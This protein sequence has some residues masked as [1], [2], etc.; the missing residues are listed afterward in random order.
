LFNTRGGDTRWDIWSYDFERRK[1]T[2][3]VASAFNETG[4]AFSPDGKWIAFT[5]DAS[6]DFQVYIQSSADATVQAQVSTRGGVQPQWRR[7]GKELYYVA[8]DN[9]IMAAAIDA[10]AGTIRAAAPQPLFTANIDQTS[11]LRNQY[12]VSA[13]GQRF[14]LLSLVNRHP[15]PIVV[16]L[17]WTNAHR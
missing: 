11:T 5:S 17:N 7:D 8:P 3:R 9:T 14:L 15:L 10:R 2:P 16:V 13:D 12:A 1:A 6:Q 4:G